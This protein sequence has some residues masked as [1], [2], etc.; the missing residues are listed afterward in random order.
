MRWPTV[1]GLSPAR[2]VP[3]RVALLSMVLVALLG[4]S[5]CGIAHR[6]T[7]AGGSIDNPVWLSDGLIYYRHQTDSD[8]PEELWRS[9][10]DGS[11][12]ARFIAPAS[13]SCAGSPLLWHL[14]PGPGGG[15]GASE[16]CD[17]SSAV[18]MVEYPMSG[19]A[20]IQLAKA[21]GYFPSWPRGGH[22]GY[23]AHGTKDCWGVGELRDGVVVPSTA[24]VTLNGTTWPL[25]PGPQGCPPDT[26]A[27]KDPAVS[28]DGH[29]LFVLATPNQRH[30]HVPGATSDSVPWQLVR[31]DE[32]G[33]S[34]PLGPTLPGLTGT[35]M[36]P[37]G[38]TVAVAERPRD[39]E[40]VILIPTD[41]GPTRDVPVAA[42]SL[43][44]SFSPDSRSL[45]TTDDMTLHII[46]L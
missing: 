46:P 44:F 35:V 22:T 18:D 23:I 16:Q 3:R 40:R 31:I 20:P 6:V 7:S 27:A 8:H 25:S 28:P 37:D 42:T 26:G 14:F 41:G 19:G 45:V 2:P 11:H 38:R 1:P 36:S 13:S 29:H 32:D 9:R 30:L 5:G 15:L 24:K 4:M 39:H 12:A 33:S 17:G 43:G 34:V 21:P 10:P